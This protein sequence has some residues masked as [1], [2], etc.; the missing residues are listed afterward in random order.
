[1]Y[2]FRA[3]RTWLIPQRNIQAYVSVWSTAAATEATAWLD[4]MEA[5]LVL[6]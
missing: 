3:G 1:M 6:V 4:H 2:P 5:A